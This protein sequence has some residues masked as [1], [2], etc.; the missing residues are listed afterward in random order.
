MRLT[1]I[2]K[3]ETDYLILSFKTE[4]MLTETIFQKVC[5]GTREQKNNA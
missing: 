5:E 1:T 2:I 4:G 3:I